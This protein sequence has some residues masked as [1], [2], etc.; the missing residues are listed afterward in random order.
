[1]TDMVS[2]VR[3]SQIM[4]RIKGMDTVPEIMVRRVLHRMG[5][6]FRLHVSELPGKPD[7]VMPR[8]KL[9]VLVNGCFWHGHKCSDGHRPKSNT[10]YWIRKLD[11]NIVRDKQTKRLLR[12]KGWRVVTIWTCQCREKNKIESI[13][14]KAVKTA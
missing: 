11:R 13:I 4:A 10:E 7:I 14:H 1:M 12:K 2:A 8:H 5:Y 9:V 6:R 3:R